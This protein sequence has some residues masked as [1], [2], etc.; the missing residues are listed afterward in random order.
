[1]DRLGGVYEVLGTTTR[2]IYTAEK[3]TPNPNDLESFTNADHRVDIGLI[4]LNEI[5]AGQAKP[6]VYALGE[7]L[8]PVFNLKLDDKEFDPIGRYVV[9][10][11]QKLGRQEG[12]ILAY[13]YEW[14]DSF[15]GG[16]WFA[17]DYLIKG[18]GSLPF[19][20]PGDS[21][22]L[23]VTDDDDRHPIAL[24]WGG[25]QRFD[26]SIPA[27]QTLAYATEIGLVLKLLDNAEIDW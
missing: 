10:V 6:G 17:T 8:G 2:S 4:E 5:T 21:G 16:Q 3:D 13:G 19:A 14:R 11:G 18:E 23:V 7:P 15:T 1:M 27:Q 26:S 24:L 22:K 9:G 25:E 12:R 20:A